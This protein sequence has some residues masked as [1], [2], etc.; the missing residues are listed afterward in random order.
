MHA[1]CDICWVFFIIFFVCV[2]VCVD[3]CV[4]VGQPAFDGLSPPDSP[5]CGFYTCISLLCYVDYGK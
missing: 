5:P 4:L 2:C 1:P 3:V